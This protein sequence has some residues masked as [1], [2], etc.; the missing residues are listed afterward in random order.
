MSRAKYSST[1]NSVPIW[2]TAVNDAPA[3]SEKNTRDAIARCPDDDTGRNSVTPCTTA[4]KTT[5]G[6]DIA[7]GV[8]SMRPRAES[9][10]TT[11]APTTMIT[12]A[13]SSPTT[14]CDGPDGAVDGSAV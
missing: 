13:I 7:A 14:V 2:M 6:H 4:R 9:H 11:P 10:T 3:S 8:Q 1:A 5:C 12:Q